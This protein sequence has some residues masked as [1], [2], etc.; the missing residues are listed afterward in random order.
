IGIKDAIAALPAGRKAVATKVLLAS[1]GEGA[2]QGT[3]RLTR[4]EFAEAEAFSRSLVEAFGAIA[5]EEETAL[6]KAR[7]ERARQ[8]HPIEDVRG[9]AL[10]IR[11]MQQSMA[12]LEAFR[13]T[14]E[15]RLQRCVCEN[16]FPRCPRGLGKPPFFVPI[17]CLRGSYSSDGISRQ[18]VCAF[19]CRKQAMAWRSLQ[20]FVGDIRPRL[21]MNL[22]RNCCSRDEK[23]IKPRSEEHT[24][25]LQS[26]ENLV[27]RLLLEKTKIRGIQRL[28]QPGQAEL[29]MDSP[30]A[31]IGQTGPE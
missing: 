14:E 19:C 13:Q 24:S 16:W 31:L 10:E 30:S 3:A 27:C 22:A 28:H 6:L 15:E 18:E 2:F 20:Y 21:A 11:Q 4:A 8:D 5:T 12:V 23:M 26:R 7:I 29:I 9:D 17:G 25:E 1:S